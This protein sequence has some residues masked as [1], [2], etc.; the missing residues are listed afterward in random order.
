[1]ASASR[2]TVTCS[3]VETTTSCSRWLGFLATSVVSLSSR[4]VSPDMAETTTTTSWPA[5]RAKRARRATLRMRSMSPTE[6]P[7]YFCTTSMDDRSE[8]A[9]DGHRAAALERNRGH[10]EARLLPGVLRGAAV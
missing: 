8:A 4:L 3:P 2:P 9:G 6:V 5:L 10:G 1:M 7:P